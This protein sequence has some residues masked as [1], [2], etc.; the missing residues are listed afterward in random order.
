MFSAENLIKNTEAFVQKTLA[1]AEGGHGWWHIDRVRKN[2]IKIA[3]KEGAD[4][5][6]TE[7][8]ALLHD[9]ADHKFH[10]GDH[11]VGPRVAREWLESQQ[12][13]QELV[14]A[15]ADIVLNNSFRGLRNENGMKSL[16][17]KCVQDADRLEALGAIGLARCL[18]YGAHAKRPL[19]DPNGPPLSL[20]APWQI[21]E[22]SLSPSTIHHFYE[23]LLHLKD[24]MNTPTGTRMAEE[25]HVFLETFLNQFFKEWNAS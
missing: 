4:L 10:G 19:Y 8:G 2:A 17:G 18:M 3:R 7:L 1:E 21:D 24:R 11:T 23:K 9:I 15:V 14:E 16:E 25:G 22:P 20:E 5:T 12:A 13:P 6:V